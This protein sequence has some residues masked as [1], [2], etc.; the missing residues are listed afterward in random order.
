MAEVYDTVRGVPGGTIPRQLP[1]GDVKMN[2]K[3]SIERVMGMHE[4]VQLAL[5]KEGMKVFQRAQF[6][7]TA[8]QQRHIMR[9][10]EAVRDANKSGDPE[11]QAKANAAYDAYMASRTQVNWSQADID[12]HVMLYRPDGREFHVEA[13]N[14][15]GGGG[16]H[17][18]T[19]SLTG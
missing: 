6:R 9:L 3:N 11:A 5:I 19:K 15:P 10:R 17:V 4:N 2:K 18:L 1:N 12:F 13:D 14:R 8:I 7:M 16:F